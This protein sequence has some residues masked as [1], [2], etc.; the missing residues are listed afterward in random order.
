MTIATTVLIAVSVPDSTT[1]LV[2]QLCGTSLAPGAGGGNSDTNVARLI[3]F[4]ERANS[5]GFASSINTRVYSGGTCATGTLTAAAAG[6]NNDTIVIA[7]RTFTLKT[8]ANLSPDS[9][10]QILIGAS[11]AATTTNI[12]NK[13]SQDPF[14]TS[15][16][17]VTNP[18]TTT[19]VF[20]ARIPGAWASTASTG[21]TTTTA[22]SGNVTF[23]A[24]QL[25]GGGDPTL[26]TSACTNAYSGYTPNAS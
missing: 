19:V 26:A 8:A 6:T 7:G 5:G 20:T 21:I 13:L 3:N 10:V 14:V 16:C 23:G 17:A 22:G 11:A 15:L 9:G 12:F 4:I 18:T 25:A 24:T 2:E 1:P